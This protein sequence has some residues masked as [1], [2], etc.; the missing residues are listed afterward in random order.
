MRAQ[1]LDLSQQPIREYNSDKKNT[2]FNRSN[3]IRVRRKC[4]PIPTQ[5]IPTADAY[6]IQTTKL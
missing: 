3:V 5:N 6:R 4:P 2:T 1:R